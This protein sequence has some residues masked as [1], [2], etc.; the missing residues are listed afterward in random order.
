ML[1][2]SGAAAD[3]GKLFWHIH[4]VLVNQTVALTE[5]HAASLGY[6]SGRQDLIAVNLYRLS[7]LR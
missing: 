3:T 7:F 5:C 6:L 1:C 4:I 2:Q